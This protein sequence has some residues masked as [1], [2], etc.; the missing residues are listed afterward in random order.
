[1]PV[2][3]AR[4]SWKFRGLSIRRDSLGYCYSRAVG[5]V[6]DWLAIHDV[7]IWMALECTERLYAFCLALLVCYGCAT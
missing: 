6:E 1:M 2:V 5:V 3:Q 4:L 7:G